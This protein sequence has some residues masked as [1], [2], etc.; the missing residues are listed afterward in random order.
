[1]TDT[2]APA[3]SVCRAP[4]TFREVARVIAVRVTGSLATRLVR[5]SEGMVSFCPTRGCPAEFGW[6]PL[7]GSAAGWG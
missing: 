4:I 7:R 3:C 5:V 2:A 1:M 6:T